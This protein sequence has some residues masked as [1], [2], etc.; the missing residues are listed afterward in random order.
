MK[1]IIVPTDF[2]APA[3][4]AANYALHVAKHLKSGITLCHAY[5]A[6]VDATVAGQIIWPLYDSD[7]VQKGVWARL[8]ERS[9]SLRQ[10]IRDLNVPNTYKPLIDCVAEP[11]AP[12]DLV[13][14]L[15]KEKSAGLVISGMSGR[16][17][18]SKFFTGST[19]RA[20]IEGAAFP[21]LL[22]PASY[23]FKPLSKIA[24]ATDLSAGDI[25]VLHS[26]A[27]FAK[28]FNAEL[29]V[30]HVDHDPAKYDAKKADLFLNE[31]TCKINYDKIYY[32]ELTSGNINDG[33]DWLSE[34]GWVDLLVMVHRRNTLVERLIKGSLTKKQA[35][36]IKI[37]L[38]VVPEGANPVF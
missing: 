14:R 16:G 33:L 2:S 35:G 10:Q 5:S 29:V 7:S 4:D 37:P 6:P 18:V 24:F 26:I 20:M 8:D 30:V 12:A 38:L 21:V 32:R 22:I 11:S 25:E 27:G 23:T 13:G 9:L 34:H 31:V 36:R 17:A 1:T 28:Y 19:S 15:V 3:D